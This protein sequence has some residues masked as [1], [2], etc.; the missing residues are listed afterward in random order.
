MCVQWICVHCWPEFPTV[1]LCGPLATGNLTTNLI[2]NNN[3]ISEWLH[4][5]LDVQTLLTPLAI[6][7]VLYKGKGLQVN[8]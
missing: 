6:T 5:L 4:I 1:I 3:S 2:Y 8:V 7:I